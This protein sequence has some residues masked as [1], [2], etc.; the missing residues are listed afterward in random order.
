MTATR[1]TRRAWQAF[2]ALM[3]ALVLVVGAFSA[4]AQAHSTDDWTAVSG[5]GTSNCRYPDS[6]RTGVYADFDIC[7]SGSTVWVRAFAMD[8]V[9]GDG[10]CGI[11][12]ISYLIDSNRNGVYEDHRHV[13]STE[14]DCNAPFGDLS[15]WYRSN[16]P[17][18]QL[19][20]RACVGYSNGDSYACDSWR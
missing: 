7:W 10:W 16:Y 18:T 11:A 6:S 5:P 19:W 14:T 13:R 4:P 3:S 2:G 20:G 1:T 17:T 8:T 9:D 15:G 12:Q